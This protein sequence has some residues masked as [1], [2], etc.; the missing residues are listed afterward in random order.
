MECCAKFGDA[1]SCVSTHVLNSGE[2]SILL[3][4]FE[5]WG[6][7]SGGIKL[8][9]Y[10]HGAARSITLDFG[11]FCRDARRASMIRISAFFLVC[12]PTSF[13]RVS[14]HLI[15]FPLLILFHGYIHADIIR[16]LFWVYSFFRRTPCVSTGVFNSLGN[17]MGVALLDN[18]RK[19]RRI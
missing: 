16:R 10:S 8:C 5:I 12:H 18:G 7:K 11:I 15:S 14:N 1:K 4:L 19:I 9:G 3:A 13:T 2:N 17:Y 6:G